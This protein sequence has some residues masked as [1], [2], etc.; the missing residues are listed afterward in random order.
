MSRI[1]LFLA[2]MTGCLACTHNPKLSQ[3]AVQGKSLYEQYCANCHQQNGTGLGRLYPPL[4]NSEY[5]KKDPATLADIIRNG[6]QGSI[7]V[8]GNEYNQP[9]SGNPALTDLEI[10]EILTYINVSWGDGRLID[11][12]SVAQ[13]I[14][15]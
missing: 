10:A 13:K 12:K 2:L 8:N 4:K 15:P 14:N 7:L 5:L 11:V 3:Y 6:I 9:M 1:F